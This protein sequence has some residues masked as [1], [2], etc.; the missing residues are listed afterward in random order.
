M[1]VVRR[2]NHQEERDM[3]ITTIKSDIRLA[4]AALAIVFL[5]V[6]AA[7]AADPAVK[8]ESGKLKES[9]KYAACRLK[10]DAKAV[11]KAVAADYTKCD[12][13]F[14]DKWD[15]T[16]A[17]AG[18][19]ICP[20]EGDKVAVQ[21]DITNLTTDLGLGL[22]GCPGAVVGGACWLL[23]AAQDNCDQTCTDAGRVYDAA[24]ETFAGSSGTDTNCMRVL[25]ATGASSS[26]G[27]DTDTEA[28]GFFPTIGC[29]YDDFVGSRVRC[30]SVATTSTAGG[31]EF[32]VRACACAPAP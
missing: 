21:A 8:C 31:D 1:Y 26:S 29:I 9:S 4:T 28:C 12:S 7:H 3:T 2:A 11:S 13:K 24:T 6:T 20:S 14:G 23:G 18:P 30:D 19:G 5:S 32:V 22:A 17:K 27:F 10:A 16:E 15:K 25:D